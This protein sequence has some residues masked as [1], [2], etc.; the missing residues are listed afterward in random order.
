MLAVGGFTAYSE[1]GFRK[2]SESLDAEIAT[3]KRQRWDRPVLRGAAAE[4]NAAAAALTALRGFSG[5]TPE[6]RDV[7]ASHLYFGEALSAPHL[8]LL[9]QHETRIAALHAAT[10]LAWSMTEIA[11]EQGESA[12]APPYPLVMD[13]VL[14]ALSDGARGDPDGCLASSAD[15]L[16]LG[17]DLVPGA[18][19]EAASLSA[20]ITSVAAPLITRCAS[21]AE[22]E[23]LARTA[24]ELH[25][26]ATQPPP[27]GGNIEL[28]DLLAKV[29][30]RELARL[31]PE[32]GD[33]GPLARLSGRPRLLEALAYFDKPARWRE[34][35]ADRYPQTFETWLKEQ[36]WRARAE[37]P[38]V[39]DATAHVDGW[40]LDDMRGQALLRALT[41]GL[42]TVTERARRKRLPDE[43]VSLKEPA[44]RDPFN[45]RPLKW[46]VAQDGGEL[47]IWSV[48]EDR[49]DDKGSSDWTAQAPIDVVVHFR[50]PPLAEPASTRRAARR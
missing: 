41:V 48:G 16:R 33:D 6:Q 47:A 1:L 50:L 42:A 13:A 43:P 30:V 37:L 49:R 29:Q 21:R 11:I 18:P 22:P 38:V 7:L 35:S 44:L 3:Y 39:P 28:A 20:R 31:F 24:R 8:A 25:V 40:L 23:T 2:L 46:R 36:E 26:M 14:L 32:Q 27:I 45:A 15:M 9:D 17:Q 19:L 4:G 10:Q 5:L 34:H 12:T